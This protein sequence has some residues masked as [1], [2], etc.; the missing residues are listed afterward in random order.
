MIR[1]ILAL[2]ASGGISIAILSA[3]S[4]PEPANAPLPNGNI[5]GSFFGELY[6][7]RCTLEIVFGSYAS[8]IDGRVRKDVSALLG[9]DEQVL[10]VDE[11]AWGREG[12]VAVCADFSRQAAADAMKSKI[13][14]VISNYEPTVGP[15]TVTMGPLQQP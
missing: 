1:S 11:K 12:E 14:A 13:D 5:S 15:V 10:A 9:N 7:R 4:E 8:G 3:C 6:G 2:F